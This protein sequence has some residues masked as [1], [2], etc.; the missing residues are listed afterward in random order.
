MTDPRATPDA[1]RPS[2]AITARVI[3][4]LLVALGTLPL[5]NWIP[6][7][8]SDGGYSRR[9]FDWLLGAAICGGVGVVVMILG[10]RLFPALST[11]MRSP[12]TALAGWIE[13]HTRAADVLLALAAIA[14]YSVVARV[15]FDGRPLLID[16]IVQ[17]LQARMYA[18]GH[19][20][21]PTDSA[22]EF[23]SILHVV[24]TG[25][26]TYS[27][28]PPGWSVMLVP[29][30]WLGATWLIGPVC[31][32]VAGWTFAALARRAL[33]AARPWQVSVLAL[34]FLASPFAAFQFASHMSHG[35][36][37]MW[38]LLALLWTVASW[39]A[40][41]AGDSH[42]AVARAFLAGLAAGCAF[43]VRP[44]DAVAFGVATAGWWTIEVFRGRSRFV[45][46]ASAA[47]GLAVPVAAVMVVNASTTGS[48]LQFGYTALWG[49]AHG[50]GFHVAPWGD[51]HTPARG[52]EIL[53]GYVS[54]LNT[55][56]FELP[57]PSLLPVV[58][59]LV[60]SRRFSMIERILWTGLAI[61]GLLYFAYWHDGF[62][63]GPRFMVPWIPSLVLALGR[64]A[65]DGA[66][67]TWPARARH[68]AFGSALA[69]VG[70]AA[71][72]SIP[73][74]A[75]QYRA[76][77]TS[78]R[79]DYGSEARRAGIEHALV[80]V[81]ESWGAQLIARLWALGVSRPAAARFYGSVD[82]C[83]LEH[84]ITELEAQPRV[85]GTIA[86]D[87]LRPLLA[88]SA[89]VVSSTVSP[90]TTERMRPGAT[91]D[92]QCT[93]HVEADREGYAL[94]PP[95]LLD[96]VS[97]NVYA[98]DLQTRDT[99]I[100]RRY[101]DRTAFMLRRDG[102]DGNSPLVWERIR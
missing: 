45:T 34:V 31:G 29:G 64:F 2:D 100:M 94:L 47:A 26:R 33:P 78:M 49:A 50:L 35:P 65:N 32:G 75:A 39:D 85:R 21:V 77:L 27:Q 89:R 63:L 98:R 55:Y 74:R 51:A 91:Y 41:V 67:R 9:W 22:P 16:E 90:D 15:V 102:V 8:L 48:P 23:F 4:V 58:V 83:A 38:V 97:G 88:D 60:F 13:R 53:A 70:M 3:A 71:A 79:T 52:L 57:F 7:G 69:G 18:S 44:L 24:D 81:R 11:A 42:R 86:E 82:A 61:H 30:V 5:A 37:L 46:L 66:W 56:L 76:G 96:D 87:A 80:F 59:A 10:P 54:R 93:M 20:S 40:A 14:G 36:L 92:A 1:V 99:A 28:F 19:L 6:A 25:L 17:V 43:A 73:F 62:F 101:P 68:L 84:R 12:G 72:I 95:I